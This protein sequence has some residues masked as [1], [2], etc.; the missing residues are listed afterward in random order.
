MEEA[1]TVLLIFK[2]VL[3][4]FLNK[5][6]PEVLT[7]VKDSETA[8]TDFK[9][10]IQDFEKK[11]VSSVKKGLPETANGLEKLK[12]AMSDC[13]SAYTNVQKLINALKQLSSPWKF[14]YHIGKDIVV[15][16]KQIFKEITAAKTDYHAQQWENFGKDLGDIIGILIGFDAKTTKYSKCPFFRHHQ[17]KRMLMGNKC[18][19]DWVNKNVKVFKTIKYTFRKIDSK[20]L[21]AESVL[22]IVTKLDAKCGL[23]KKPRMYMDVKKADPM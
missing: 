20:L 19:A 5:D 23:V 8:F 2:G 16:R 1:K 14:A 3:E 11:T 17:Q 4:G 22:K 21:L 15:N 12:D 7:C 9:S 10:A 6:A 13:G 18:V